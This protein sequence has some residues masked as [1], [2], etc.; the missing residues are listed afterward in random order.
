MKT[1]IFFCMC[2]GMPKL[3]H[4]SLLRL[5][6]F[7]SCCGSWTL[8][9]IVPLQQRSPVL[10]WAALAGVV[11]RSR[12]GILPPYWELVR[13]YLE[14]PGLGSP[15]KKRHGHTVESPAK[16]L[17]IIRGLECLRKAERID[18]VQPGEKKA[19]G[20]FYQCAQIRE[21]RLQRKQPGSFPWYPM[22][23]TE[24]CSEPWTK[25]GNPLWTLR[26]FPPP[27]PPAV[28]MTGK[29]Y[30]ETLWSRVSLH[31]DIQKLSGYGHEQPT[32]S[33]PAW[34]WGLDKW[35][36]EVSLTSSVLWL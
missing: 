3:K 25:T 28:R 18:I 26:V 32:L 35:G 21:G 2:S 20:E 36:P 27:P 29:I 11:C 5:T 30:A 1:L 8:T 4:T 23:Q 34:A 12:E 22:T 14:S 19:H 33:S 6:L 31:A 13:P 16:A 17:K 15:V 9:S 7:F 10:S 24:L